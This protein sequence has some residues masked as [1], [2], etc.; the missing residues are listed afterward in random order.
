MYEKPGVDISRRACFFS[1][2]LGKEN[3][4]LFFARVIHQAGEETA[5]SVAR[6]AS[7]P[8][9]ASGSGTARRWMRGRWSSLPGFLSRSRSAA[10]QRDAET[11]RD[12]EADG[13]GRME[14]PEGKRR[15]PW[16]VE[17]PRHGLG[18]RSRP[19]LDQERRE[20]QIPFSLHNLQTM[21]LLSMTRQL[22]FFVF[23]QSAA[24]MN[25]CACNRRCLSSLAFFFSASA[26]ARRPG[27]NVKRI[28][29]TER[30]A[31]TGSHSKR[32]D[33]FSVMSA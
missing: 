21:G 7:R 25:R 2:Q 4:P 8:G 26:M 27:P 9:M 12:T 18:E 10:V 11:R 13:P 5:L 31:F 30:P 14:G 1:V 6:G 24:R 17:R 32:R 23:A 19:A 29:S 16:R 3:S 22:P 28:L 20:A 33:V 15:S